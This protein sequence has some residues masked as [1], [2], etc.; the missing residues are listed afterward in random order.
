M[1]GWRGG[2]GC[3]LPCRKPWDD[4]NKN[5]LA[6]VMGLAGHL[7]VLSLRADFFLVFARNPLDPSRSSLFRSHEA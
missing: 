4:E 6:K 5:V 3:C 1:R 2:V 7:L